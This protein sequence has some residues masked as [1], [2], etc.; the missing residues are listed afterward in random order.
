MP[1]CFYCE[2]YATLQPWKGLILVPNKKWELLLVQFSIT[3]MCHRM[4]IL[5]Y[6]VLGVPFFDGA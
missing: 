3:A 6:C 4:R 2:V 1:I 5:H